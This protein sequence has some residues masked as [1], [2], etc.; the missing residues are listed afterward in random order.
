MRSRESV[1]VVSL[2]YFGGIERT[3]QAEDTWTGCRPTQLCRLTLG[4]QSFGGWQ[5]LGEPLILTEAQC[6]WSTE[7]PGWALHLP[8]LGLV[9][10][11][12]ISEDCVGEQ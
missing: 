11:S 1:D 7:G 5:T 2:L 10:C 4:V 6:V 12:R 3:L 8:D 9:A